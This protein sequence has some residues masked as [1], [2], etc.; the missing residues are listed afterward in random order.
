[1]Y[2]GFWL[3]W[4]RLAFWFFSRSRFFMF[5]LKRLSAFNVLVWT[6]FLSG[7]MWFLQFPYIPSPSASTISAARS[8]FH[9]KDHCWWITGHLN[10]TGIPVLV[11]QAVKWNRPAG[12]LVW[13]SRTAEPSVTKP[14]IALCLMPSTLSAANQMEAPCNQKK[15]PNQESNTAVGFVFLLSFKSC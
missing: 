8:S 3:K 12:S 5:P 10:T 1:M 7:T 11:V 2:L 13:A 4:I 9:S 15:T 14:G 6:C